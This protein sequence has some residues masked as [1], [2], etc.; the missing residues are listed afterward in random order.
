MA[1]ADDDWGPHNCSPRGK[2]R[3]QAEKCETCIFHPGNR[4]KLRPGRVKQMVDDS[5]NE[6]TAIICHDTLGES[7]QAVC[8]GFYEA[9]KT[10]P[11]Q[12]AERLD[13]IEWVTDS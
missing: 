4:M 11:L 7:E 5:V 9:H 12:I 8:H 2:L 1:E 3:I 6:G 10:M 13:L